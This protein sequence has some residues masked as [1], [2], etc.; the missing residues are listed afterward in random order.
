MKRL[1]VDV[2]DSYYRLT[3]ICQM[4]YSYYYDVIDNASYHFLFQNVTLHHN[5]LHLLEATRSCVHRL[6]D[7]RSGDAQITAVLLRG[8]LHIPL[9]HEYPVSVVRL[10]LPPSR[11]RLLCEGQ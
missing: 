2:V 7:K 10:L 11:E 6:R 9:R 3:V 4:S 8:I 1:F 5:E